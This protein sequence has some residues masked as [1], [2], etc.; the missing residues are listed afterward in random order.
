[1][2]LNKK[3]LL[4]WSLILLAFFSFRAYQHNTLAQGLTPD[5]QTKTLTGEPAFSRQNK[6]VLIHFWATWCR[7]CELENDN[8]QTLSK[9]YTVLN[10]AMQSGSDAEVI[11]Y[12]KKNKIQLGNLIN[13]QSGTLAKLMGVKATP[14]SF[15][16]NK[17]NKIQFIEVGYVS[18]LGYQLRLKWLEW[19][20]L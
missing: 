1:M 6:P 2:T 11:N 8:I 7:I 14:T 17:N 9:N 15:F 3:S 18:T 16:I 20:S 5:F 13:D 4:H 12:A 10:I 19:S